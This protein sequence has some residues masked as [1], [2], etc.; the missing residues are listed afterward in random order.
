MV[1][2]YIQNPNKLG[3]F[4]GKLCLGFLLLVC[5][6]DSLDPEDERNDQL[7]CSVPV[8]DIRSTALD[9]PYTQGEK[10]ADLDNP[11][12]LTPGQDGNRLAAETQIAGFYL[13]ETPVAIAMSTLHFHVTANFDQSNG[14]PG[15]AISYS[16]FTE[17]VRG[18]DRSEFGQV[19]LRTGDEL[20]GPSTVLFDQ[21]NGNSL[22]SH[23]Q[24]KAIC[25][26][27][28]GD[29]LKSVPV[30]RMDYQEWEAL[31]PNTLFV[32]QSEVQP[33]S[34]PYAQL[35]QIDQ[36]SYPIPDPPVSANSHPGDQPVLVFPDSLAPQAINI[37]TT[38]LDLQI[39]SLNY[40]N[41][42][43][44]VFYDPRTLVANAFYTDRQFE[45]NDFAFK[46]QTTGSAWNYLGKATS[47]PLQGEQMEW[48]P[49]VFVTNWGGLTGFYPN[50]SIVD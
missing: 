30:V 11:P 47:G 23:F 9:F 43:V 22:W 14:D 6:C 17:S 35:R 20:Y 24:A 49:E 46:D 36:A 15:L 33:Y 21:T 16:R 38:V 42:D 27:R 13:G 28:S 50:S 32:E 2:A 12:L 8:T 29:D 18:F 31:N 45:V 19:Q 10:Q 48:V 7:S 4:F 3:T 5:A 25:G 41:R 37:G 34:L 40:M 26:P 44:V 39:R 1:S